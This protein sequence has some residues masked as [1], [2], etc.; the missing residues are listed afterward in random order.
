MKAWSVF[1]LLALTTTA[2]YSEQINKA[3]AKQI[4]PL[5]TEW[6]TYYQADINSFQCD[7]TISEQQTTLLPPS[8]YQTSTEEKDG[9]YYKRYEKQDD[10]YEPHLFSYSPNKRYYINLW[11][12]VGIYKCQNGK[13]CL[14]GRDDSQELYLYDRKLKRK[15]M[16]L[17][18]GMSQSAEAVFWSK[19]NKFIIVGKEFFDRDK[20]FIFVNHRY[21][22][23]EQYTIQKDRPSYIDYDLQRHGILLTD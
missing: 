5:I 1:I 21:C 18:L 13:Y 19:N 4:K 2:V 12:Q 6:L 10:I 15:D 16:V 14:I 20:L 7:D 23:T 3:L 22:T 11:S 17:W 8:F 9:M